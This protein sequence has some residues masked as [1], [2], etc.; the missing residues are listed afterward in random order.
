[1]KDLELEPRGKG[2][3]RITLDDNAMTMAMKLS[4]GNPGA[5]TVCLKLIENNAVVD[6]ISAWGSFGT[7][8]SLDSCGI[9]SYQIW[10]LFKDVCNQDI[11]K[12]IALMR[13]W[14]F[15]F[16]SKEDLIHAIDNRGSGINVDDLMEKVLLR[17]EDFWKEGRENFLYKRLKR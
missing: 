10:M 2:R 7:L 15:G 12:V 14:G 1:M 16:V 3:E 5:V 4:E 13:A 9:Y 17:L 6:P 8:I 11:V